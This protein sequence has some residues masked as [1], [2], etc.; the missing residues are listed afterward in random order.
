[1]TGGREQQRDEL[2]GALRRRLRAAIGDD[3]SSELDVDEHVETVV[4]ALAK[5]GALGRRFGAQRK[6]GASDG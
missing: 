5:S 3:H 1:M 6:Q 4:A 2:L